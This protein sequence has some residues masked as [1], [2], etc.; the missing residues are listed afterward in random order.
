MLT[1]LSKWVINSEFVN[2]LAFHSLGKKQP[3]KQH[4]FVNGMNRLVLRK[5]LQCVVAQII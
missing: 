5:H 1:H 3:R 2:V 4:Q